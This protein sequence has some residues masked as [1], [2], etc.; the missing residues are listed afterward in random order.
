MNTSTRHPHRRRH[1]R[2]AVRRL[3]TVTA[4]ACLAV[5]GISFALSRSAALPQAA[6]VPAR[7]AASQA[8]DSAAQAQQAQAML[9]AGADRIGASA[10]VGLM[11]E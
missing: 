1:L 9:D 2:P 5:G 7:S 10:L 4:A 11:E 6:S 8:E 3:L